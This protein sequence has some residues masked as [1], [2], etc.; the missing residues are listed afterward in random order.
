MMRKAVAVAQEQ[1][2]QFNNNNTIIDKF[3]QT[4]S[5]VWSAQFIRTLRLIMFKYTAFCNFILP[6]N[7][8]ISIVMNLFC[9]HI[10]YIVIFMLKFYIAKTSRTT[11]WSL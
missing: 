10:T 6:L 5:N 3:G 4:T 8:Y 11:L 9:K 2:Q 7:K 1:I